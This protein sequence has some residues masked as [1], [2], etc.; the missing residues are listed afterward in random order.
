VGADLVAAV[1][2]NA[3]LKDRLACALADMENL[4]DRTAR[5]VESAKAFAVSGLAKNLFDVFME[6]ARAAAAV[7]ADAPDADATAPARLTALVEGVE[8]TERGLHSAL[9]AAG[10]ERV[11]V[12]EG[13]EFDPNEMDAAFSVP[14]TPGGPP[15]GAVAAFTKPG[16]RLNGRVVRL[17]TVGVVQGGVMMMSFFLLLSTTHSLSLSFAHLSTMH[18]QLL[19]TLGLLAS[20]ASAVS[21]VLAGRELLALGKKHARMGRA[22]CARASGRVGM[23]A[24]GPPP[25]RPRQGSRRAVPA[26]WGHERGTNVGQTGGGPSC[27]HAQQPS[28]PSPPFPQGSLANKTQAKLADTRAAL[29]L[30]QKSLPAPEYSNTSK[31]RVFFD[32]QPDPTGE[33]LTSRLPPLTPPPPPLPFPPSSTCSK[34]LPTPPPAR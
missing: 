26:T 13:A 15:A 8:L 31:V 14:P 1:Q 25:P 20:T 17:A 9:R 7:G 23:T 5:Q 22:Q 30:L 29:A 24:R 2:A 27:F 4:R 34:A 33:R 3:D 32:V 12:E 11:E 21:V 28:L 18:L 6:R 10:V 16:Y 19:L